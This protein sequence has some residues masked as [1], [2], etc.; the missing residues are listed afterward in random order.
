[1]RS[2][3]VGVLQKPSTAA[4]L[5]EGARAAGGMNDKVSFFWGVLLDN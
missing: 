4:C 5:P 2:G 1:M 3:A